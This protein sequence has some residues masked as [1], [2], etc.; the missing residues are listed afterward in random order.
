M[1]LKFYSTGETFR[2]PVDIVG[3]DIDITLP[4][5]ITVRSRTLNEIVVEFVPKCPQQQ[6]NFTGP[7]CGNGDGP[8]SIQTTLTP[9]YPS[10][11]ISEISKPAVNLDCTSKTPIGGITYCSFALYDG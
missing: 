6:S 7:I 1:Y 2:K 11:D 5:F 8:Q 10:P 3:D 4:F 9:L